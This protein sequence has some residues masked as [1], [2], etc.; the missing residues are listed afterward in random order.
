MV[1]LNSTSQDFTTPERVREIIENPDPIARNLQITQSYHELSLALDALFG[2]LD[3]PWCAFATWAS[4][5][6]GYFI[7]NEEIPPPLRRFLGHNGY[8][9][10]PVWKP[11]GLL[12]SD[13][14]LK[15]AR[16]TVE[17]VSANTA[18]GNRLVYAKMGPIFADFLNFARS[19]DAP[20]P[21]KRDVFL[22][23]LAAD[24]T[25]DEKLLRAFFHAYTA[26]FESDANTKAEHIYL[27]N[28]L[29]GWHEQ[30]RLQGAIEG[31]FKA[32]IRRALD[33]PERHFTRLPIPKVF[34]RLAATLFKWLL[35]PTIQDFE[36]DWLRVA[37]ECLITQATP[38][39]QLD[40]SEDV[41]PL[42]DGEM[43][44]SALQTLST[45]EAKMLVDQLD[46]TPNTTRGS[47]A[48][49]WSQ[50]GDRMNYV[51]DYFRSRQQER[52]LLLPPFS[53]SQVEAIREGRIPAEPL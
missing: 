33:D 30:I 52:K 6:A 17:D 42:P 5:Q 1:S 35:A 22:N 3:I 8:Q 25:T 36:D 23:Q 44:P 43:Y 46:Y 31:A 49:D 37:T 40:I 20:D 38:A 15:Y 39:G 9:R 27:A 10:P 13:P 12:R 16:C 47:G 19:H 21:A 7:R 29:T 48:R 26:R 41:P 4:K 24:P 53:P 50:L 34:R 51:V 11:S 14:F 45:S 28:V 2:G 32:P 18:E